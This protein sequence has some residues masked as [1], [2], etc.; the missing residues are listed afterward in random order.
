MGVAL[1]LSQLYGPFRGLH[2]RIGVICT[3]VGGGQGAQ[4]RGIVSTIQTGCFFS[5]INGP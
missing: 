3:R 1:G 2:G 5:Q 4:M